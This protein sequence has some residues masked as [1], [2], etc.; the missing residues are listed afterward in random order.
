[1]HLRDRALP[2]LDRADLV[3]A[4]RAEAVREQHDVAFADQEFRHRLMAQRQLVATRL[5]RAVHAPAAVKR[6]DRGAAHIARTIGAEQQRGDTHRSTRRRIAV[7]RVERH[8]FGDECHRRDAA[9]H[10]RRGQPREAL[11]HGRLRISVRP[12]S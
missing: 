3:A 5:E 2:I 4:A 12:S 11:R 8:A 10:D 9:G 1:M 6:D 7:E